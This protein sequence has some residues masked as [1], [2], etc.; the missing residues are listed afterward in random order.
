MRDD[1]T[2]DD[3]GSPRPDLDKMELEEMAELASTDRAARQE[4]YRRSTPTIAG[5]LADDRAA[6]EFDKARLRLAQSLAIDVSC[7]RLLEMHRARERGNDN[8]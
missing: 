5:A 3:I 7:R 8:E 2:T 4:A 6:D 1:R